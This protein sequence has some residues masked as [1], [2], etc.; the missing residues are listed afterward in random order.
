[1]QGTELLNLPLKHLTLLL[2]NF[3][4]IINGCLCSL[5]SSC[6]LGMIAI[7]FISS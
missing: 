4:T 1:M 3:R 5:F 2:F 6:L 7:Y